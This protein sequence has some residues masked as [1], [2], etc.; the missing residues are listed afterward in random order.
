MI[1]RAWK[2]LILW[3]ISILDQAFQQERAKKKK[4]GMGGEEGFQAV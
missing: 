1:S 4:R 3:R 2:S